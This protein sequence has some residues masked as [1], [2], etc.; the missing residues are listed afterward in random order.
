MNLLSIINRKEHL[1]QDDLNNI[2]KDL[3]EIICNS[4]ILVIGGAG[5]IGQAV[6][7]EICKRKPRLLHV[8]DLSENNLVELVR[9]IRSSIGYFSGEFKTFALDCGSKEFEALSINQSYDFIFNLSALKHVRSEK[10]PFTLMRL[11]QVN[12][13]NTIKTL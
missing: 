4:S 12:I 11:I 7:I 6:S 2:E 13:F 1:F 8:V 9:N 5:S 3:Q 10:D